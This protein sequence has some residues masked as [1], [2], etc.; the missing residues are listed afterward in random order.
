MGLCFI[1]GIGIPSLHVDL[2][3]QCIGRMTRV[4]YDTNMTICCA[5]LSAVSITA[6]VQG[7]RMR[8]LL[9]SNLHFHT[10]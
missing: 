2:L 6:R 3:A 7:A 10:P 9:S 5:K 1:L 8:L 4:H